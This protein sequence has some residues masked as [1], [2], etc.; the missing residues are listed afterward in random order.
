M[1]E[2]DYNFTIHKAQ[3]KD[4]PYIVEFQQKMAFETE[5]LQLN[6]SILTKGVNTLFNHP[7]KGFYLVVISEETTIASVLLTPEWSDWRN[8]TFLWIQS[9]YVMPDFRKLGVFRQMYSNVKSMVDSSE[10]YAGIKLYVDE[11]NLVAQIAYSHVGMRHSHYRLFEW[12]KYIVIMT[13]SKIKTKHD[14]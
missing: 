4:I 13:I 7:E 14:A 2:K 12:E 1:A 9:L 8:S 5:G 3:Q 11:H 10:E 6:N